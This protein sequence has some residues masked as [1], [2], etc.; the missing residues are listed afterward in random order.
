MRIFLLE[1]QKIVLAYPLNLF[2]S[3]LSQFQENIITID[4]EKFPSFTE[5]FDIESFIILSDIIHI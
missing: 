5:R 4:H 3:I 2:T 1:K